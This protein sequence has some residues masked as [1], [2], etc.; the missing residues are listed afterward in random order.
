VTTLGNSS[1]ELDCRA[2]EFATPRMLSTTALVA[3]AEA[4]VLKDR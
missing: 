1:G 4:A 2:R 3:A